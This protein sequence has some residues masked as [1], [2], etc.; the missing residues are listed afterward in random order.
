MAAMHLVCEPLVSFHPTRPGIPIVADGQKRAK[1]RWRATA[2][3]GP[4]F[5]FDLEVPMSNGAVAPAVATAQCVIRQAAEPW[6]EI[7]LT[8]GRELAVGGPFR[9]PAAGPPDHDHDH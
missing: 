1:C 6:V 5:G 9:S 7:P 2:A 8:A 4:R 3:D